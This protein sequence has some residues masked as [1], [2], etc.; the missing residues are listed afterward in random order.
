MKNERGLCWREA[1]SEIPQGLS[2]DLL[3]FN[4]FLSDL[5]TKIKDV[6]MK[7]AKDTKPGDILTAKKD[8]RYS[9]VIW[10]MEIIET[11]RKEIAQSDKSPP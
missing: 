7:L 10:R 4:I 6:I 2:L 3:F 5:G 8:R 1:I 9:Q 11:L